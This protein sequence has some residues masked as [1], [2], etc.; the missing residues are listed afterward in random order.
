MMPTTMARTS[1]CV[2]GLGSSDFATVLVAPLVARCAS[3][4]FD[5]AVGD[6][7]DV[8]NESG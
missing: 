6:M 8:R 5:L 7:N 4:V 1:G 3:F 2:S